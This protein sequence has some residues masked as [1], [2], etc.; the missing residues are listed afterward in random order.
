[1]TH[2]IKSAED[3]RWFLAHTQGFRDG[4]ITDVH[5]SKRRIFDEQSGHDVLAGIT[6]TVVVRYCVQ[7][8]R[9]VA[10]LMMQG[11]SDLCIFEQEGADCSLLGS[12]QVEL[13]EGKLRFWFDPEGQLYVVCEE[14]FLEEVALPQQ[15]AHR[16]GMVGQWTFQA[17]SGEAPTVCWLLEQLDQAGW[18]CY[19]KP[20]GGGASSGSLCWEGRLVATAGDSSGLAAAVTVQVYGPVDGAG[21]GMRLRLVHRGSRL[22]GRLLN[23]VAEVVTRT[24][25]GTCLMEE[26]VLSR[27]AWTDRTS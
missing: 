15:E 4:Q 2:M 18:S 13:S 24:F 17:D 10:R 9:R 26:M 20:S 3:L 22:E 12:I 8:I 5:V 7:D 6:A 11:V 23:L 25:P 19:W 1:M 16:D 27:E 14:A 21:F